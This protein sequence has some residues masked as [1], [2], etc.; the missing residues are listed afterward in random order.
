[1]HVN[2]NI[3]YNDLVTIVKQLPVSELKRLNTTINNEIV[4]KKQAKTSTLQSL[5][6][7]APTWSDVEYDEYQSIRQLI[8]KSRLA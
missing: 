3:A 7:K 5:I 8:N 6:L 4:T 1:M 2:L